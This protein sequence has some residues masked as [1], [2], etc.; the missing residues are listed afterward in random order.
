[1]VLHCPSGCLALH[2]NPPV[3]GLNTHIHTPGPCA[4]HLC[5]VAQTSQASQVEAVADGHVVAH[6]LQ[7]LW[8]VEQRA[9]RQCIRVT[10]RITWAAGLLC[11]AERRLGATGVH[12]AYALLRTCMAA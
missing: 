5:E 1:M 3:H 6:H 9:Q 7:R 4:N 2:D 10:Q 8:E 11:C 12:E